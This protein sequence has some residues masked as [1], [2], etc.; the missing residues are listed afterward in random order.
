MFIKRDLT[1]K[2]LAGASQSPVIAVVGPRQ[3]GKSTLIKEIFP[4]HA[5]IDLQ[6]AQALEFAN[7]DP[8]GFIT[9]YQNQFGLI[10][11]EAQYAPQLFAQIK[12]LVDRQPQAGFYILS[13]SQNFLLHEKISESLAGRVYLYQLLPLSIQELKAAN[14][15]PNQAGT[16]ITQGCYPR[17]YQPQINPQEYYTNY[18]QTYVQRDIRTI[19]NIENSSAFTKFIQLCALRIGSTLN[20]TDLATSCGI[21][22]N[23]ARDWLTLL[24][25]S[26]VIFLLQ[27]YHQNLGK[28]ITKSPKLYFYDTGLACSLIG[29]SHAQ[30]ILNRNLYGALFE[31]LIIIDILKQANSANSSYRFSFFRDSNQREVDLIVEQGL[32]ATPIEIKSSQTM[33]NSYFEVASWFHNQLPQSNPPIV[34]YGG[35]QDQSRSIGQVLSWNNSSQLFK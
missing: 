6:D 15:L 5:Y 13:G 1:L 27:P 26:F 32:T 33:H 2:I 14:L 7:S 9:S 24:E 3:S 22:V 16:L 31:N 23:T 35:D 28:R 8:Q 4:K 11:D 30:L 18:L 29:I 12:V 21:S 19:R 17:V 34:I 20:L 10:I 25:T